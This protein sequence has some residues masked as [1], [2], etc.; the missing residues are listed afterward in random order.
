MAVF[1][2]PA[3]VA[4]PLP[5]RVV[6][7]RVDH[8]ADAWPDKPTSDAQVGLRLV[9]EADYQT[10]RTEAARRA[11][12]S[13]PDEDLDEDERVD[14]Y[15][16][17]LAAWI[18]A[19]GTTQPDDASKPWMQMAHDNMQ[20]ALTPQGIHY[21]FDAIAVL[22]AERS[23]LSPEASDDDLVKLCE[24]LQSGVAWSSVDGP[25]ARRV[26]RLLRHA[27]DALALG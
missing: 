4:K 22:H 26:R 21:L 18:V 14:C 20:V 1:R 9:S 16:D 8:Y 2:N 10:A 5:A 25:N 7:L 6:P 19:R 15:N 23:P 11:W 27:M 17:T 24:A 13:F 12:E 3:T